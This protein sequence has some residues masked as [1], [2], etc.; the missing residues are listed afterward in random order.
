[1]AGRFRN[2]PITIAQISFP[3]DKG[4]NESGHTEASNL[5]APLVML[6]DADQIAWRAYDKPKPNTILL[7]DD[8]GKI[9]EI[10]SIE[11]LEPIARKAQILA[12][13]VQQEL[14]SMYH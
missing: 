14:E 1:M 11:D 10:G 8:N 3:F 5:D 4:P 2:D 12:M 7:I 13:K 6:C 9:V